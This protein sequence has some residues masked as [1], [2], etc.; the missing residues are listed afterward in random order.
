MTKQDAIRLF[1]ATEA[2]L[3]RAL[4][5]TRS[6]VNQWP[7]ELPQHLQDRVNGVAL[8]KGRLKFN[9]EPVTK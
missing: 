3:A 7:D 1:G 6:A 5:I 4:G 2:D 9:Y 8:R